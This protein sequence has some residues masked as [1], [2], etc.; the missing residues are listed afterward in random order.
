MHSNSVPDNQLILQRAA[1]SC[2]SLDD[3]RLRLRSIQKQLAA[4]RKRSQSPSELESSHRPTKP[5]DEI[6]LGLLQEA[7]TL[8]FQISILLSATEEPIPERQR[9][10]TPA[11]KP[12]VG[13][14]AGTGT[15]AAATTATATA[16]AA[17]DITSSEQEHA[18]TG[19][20]PMQ[21]PPLPQTADDD[22]VLAS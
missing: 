20:H 2:R 18:S 11:R 13:T 16:S 1:D 5:N 4:S 22:K 14:A 8:Q 19:S 9:K 21:S 3:L 6:L 12:P 17:A 15:G 10:S 7:Y